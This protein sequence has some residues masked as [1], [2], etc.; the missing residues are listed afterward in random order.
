MERSIT[1]FGVEDHHVG[2]QSRPEQAAIDQPGLGGIQRRH[3]AHGVFEPQ[4][5]AI[6]D[7]FAQDARERAEAARVGMTATERSL[8]RQGRAVGADRAPGLNQREVH[9]LLGVM[10]VD[11]ADRPVLFDQEVEEHVE[12]VGGGVRFRP[13]LPR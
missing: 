6:A 2:E 3:L 13:T 9:V 10:G 8:D 4:E 5:L 1:L 11:R 7:V 12:R